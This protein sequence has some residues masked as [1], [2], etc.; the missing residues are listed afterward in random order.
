MLS[1]PVK[2]L[3]CER[4]R[5]ALERFVRVVASTCGDAK[6]GKQTFEPRHG[7]KTVLAIPRT[8]LM[9]PGLS[10]ASARAT[11]AVNCVISIF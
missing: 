3:L 7:K 11:H 9:F 6:E 8:R 4:F 5:D 10:Q 1:S 2:R